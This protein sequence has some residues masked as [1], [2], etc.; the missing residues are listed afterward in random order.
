MSQYHPIAEVMHHNL[1]NRSLY[2]NEYDSVVAE[3]E[4][5]GFRNGWI[6]EMSSNVNYRPDF[7]KENPFE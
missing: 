5:L 1:L 4:R 7:R 3:M 2:K 6:Q